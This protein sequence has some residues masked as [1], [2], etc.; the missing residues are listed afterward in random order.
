[1]ARALRLLLA[2]LLSCGL[3]PARVVVETLWVSGGAEGVLMGGETL[4]GWLGVA[5]HIDRQ[6][7][8]A[9]WIDLDG[10]RD[11]DPLRQVGGLRLPD[12]TVPSP[13]LFRLWGDELLHR[14]V[15]WTLLNITPLPQFPDHPIPTPPF[16]QWTSPHGFDLRFT[17]LLPQNA[18]LLI[19][20]HSLR[21][22]KVLPPKTSLREF[23]ASDPAPAK[24]FTV[25][26]LPPDADGGDWS[27]AF[28]DVPI[29][30]EPAGARPDVIPLDDG[31]RLRI[32]PGL[33]GRAVVRVDIRWD[34]VARQFRKPHASVE[35]VRSPD[36]EALDFPP[37]L[38]PRLRP[39]PPSTKPTPL[40]EALAAYANRRLVP[41]QEPSPT[42]PAG[43]LPD[44]R[45]AA[46][47]PADTVWTRWRLTPSE[48]AALQR[49]DIPARLET[50]AD[51]ASEAVLI[52]SRLAA[53]DGG[54]ERWIPLRRFLDELDLQPDTLPLTS[55]E[56]VLPLASREDSP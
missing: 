44:A 9:W 27:R 13:Q 46:A 55:R 22:L 3:A 2:G 21:P 7:P 5:R 53:G 29:L 28:P 56:L 43:P 10:T 35:W 4:P 40:A 32:R 23:L 52:P 19:P 25:V 54:N 42:P 36:L 8:D 20:P 45:R 12:A 48:R 47:A 31:R 51:G 39:L 38:I 41:E 34:T 50:L 6:A 24:R 33:H 17:A 15:P 37:A 1:M 49:L 30:I 14:P 26:A 11:W 16:R 18:P